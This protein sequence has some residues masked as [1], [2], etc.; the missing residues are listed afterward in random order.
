MGEDAASLFGAK[1]SN[2]FPDGGVFR[3]KHGGGEKRSIDGAG[4][5]DGERADRDAAGHLRDG[6]ERVQA[7]EGLRFDGNAENGENGF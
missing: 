2:S 5:A 4:P 6:E 1:L 7:L 3:A